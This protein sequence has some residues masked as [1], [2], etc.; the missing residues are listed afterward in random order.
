MLAGAQRP[1]YRKCIG[2][3]FR[4][5]GTTITEYKAATG[6]AAAT[7]LTTLTNSASTQ[8]TALTTT[9]STS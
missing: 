1:W 8:A 2:K 4:T 9:Y 3:S 5:S 7:L 6:T